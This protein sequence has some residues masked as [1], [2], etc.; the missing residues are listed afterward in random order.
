M[1]WGVVSPTCGTF[2]CRNSSFLIAL[3]SICVQHVC[4]RLWGF[5]WGFFPLSL[6]FNKVFPLGLFFFKNL[7]TESF[8]LHLLV[9][10]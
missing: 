8:L 1:P 6:S 3:V 10:T 5:C 2:V 7:H 4:L 9:D